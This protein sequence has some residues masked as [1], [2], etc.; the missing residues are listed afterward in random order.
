MPKFDNL[1]QFFEELKLKEDATLSLSELIAN[2]K[3]Q[4]PA[5]FICLEIKEKNFQCSTTG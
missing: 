3:Q 1:P 5:N 4:I 2:F